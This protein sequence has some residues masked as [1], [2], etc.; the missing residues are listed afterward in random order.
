MNVGDI[1]RFEEKLRDAEMTL[2]VKEGVRVIYD[3][4]GSVAGKVLTAL[5]VS[6]VILSLLYSTKSMKLNINL[7]GLVSF[8]VIYFFDY[9][10]FHHTC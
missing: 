9:A 8:I 7:S 4:N 3:R 1:H 5:L 10:R 2:G 6:A